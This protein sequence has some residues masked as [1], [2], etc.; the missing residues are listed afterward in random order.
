MK[1]FIHTTG[2]KANQWDSH[3]ISSRLKEAGHTVG[4][5][6][7]A[8]FIVINACTLTDGAERDI[9]R[10]INVS[11]RE[12]GS[13][14][15]ILA[16]CH[17]QVYPDCA[18]GADVVLGQNEKFRVAD[19][20]DKKG[21]FVGSLS[22]T[23]MEGFQIDTLPK[24]RTR[25]FLKIQD[26]CDRFCSYCI[27]PY[28]RGN[29]RSRPAEETMRIMK[30]LREKGVLEVVLTGIEI[31]A[32][33][34]PVSGMKLADLLN[35][36]E[37]GDTP[38]RIRMSSV[39]PTFINDDFIEF[40]AKSVKL[41]KSIHIPLQSGSDDVLLNMGRGYK[42][43]YVK[44]ITEKLIRRIPSVG[45]GFD[46]ITGFPGEDGKRFMETVHFLQ[47]IPVYYLHVFPFSMRAGTRAA[48]MKETV[49]PGEKRERVRF[50]RQIDGMKRTVFYNRFIGTET[51]VILEN[52]LYKGQYMRGYTENYIPVHIPYDRRLENRLMR[53]VM[54]RIEEGMLIGQKKDVPFP[55]VLQEVNRHV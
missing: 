38:P 45:I 5:A 43:S 25:F 51:D 42:S 47:Q 7:E 46:V 2:C 8:D 12:N 10:F 21:V 16:G 40:M 55:R 20:L 13:V 50:L 27:V 28:A 3:V 36:F 15:I 31:S 39:D 22:D 18:F 52:K 33:H 14:S 24:G 17:G 11:R 29:P 32:Y 26:G 9:R 23:P 19:F 48:A 4:P 6:N 53:V 1:Y 34:D 35:A 44:D 30:D 41:M 37:K 54:E 49:T